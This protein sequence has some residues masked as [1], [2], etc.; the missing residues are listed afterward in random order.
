MLSHSVVFDSLGP[1]DYTHQASLS[2]GVSQARIQEWDTGILDV[3]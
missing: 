2:I 3:S 1:L